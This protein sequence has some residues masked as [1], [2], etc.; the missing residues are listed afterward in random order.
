[1][2]IVSFGRSFLHDNLKKA[3]IIFFLGGTVLCS[4]RKT[5]LKTS[6]YVYV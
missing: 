5:S 4:W 1:M 2:H 3:T 6:V